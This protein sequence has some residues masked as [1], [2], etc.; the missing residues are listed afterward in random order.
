M[1]RNRTENT[2][3]VEDVDVPSESEDT[4]AEDTVGTEAASDPSTENKAPKAPARPTPPEGFVTPSGFAAA[5]KTERGVELRPQVVYSYMKNQSKEDGFPFVDSTTLGESASR[6][7]IKVEDALGW[8]D[9]KE[10]RKVQRSQ[11]AQA[12]AAEKER[13]AAEKAVATE[14]QTGE[15]AEAVSETVAEAE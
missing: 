2:A 5:L 6:P 12:K 13:R 4:V 1:S 11:N 7:L 8:W 10:Q 3:V 9:R 15:N 14:Q